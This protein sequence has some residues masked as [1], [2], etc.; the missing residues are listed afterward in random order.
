M[1]S[2]IQ[3]LLSSLLDSPIVESLAAKAGKKAIS[4][5]KAHF[6]L[7]AQQISTAYQDSY[8]YALVAISVGVAAPEQSLAQKIFN[9]KLSREFAEQIDRHYLQPFAKQHGLS[10]E[11]LPAFRK[12]AAKSLKEFAKHKDKLFQIEQVTDDD[13]IALISYRNTSAITDLV[14]EQMRRITPVDDTLADFLRFDGQLG[15]GI[16]FFFRELIRKDDRLEKT[17]AALQREGLCLSVQQLQES[18]EHLKATQQSS[19]FLAD[20]LAPQLKQ[21]QQTQTTW[22]N[23]HEQLIRFSRGFENRLAEMLEWAKDVYSTLEQIHEDVIETQKEVKITKGLVEG[24]LEKLTEMMAR[25]DLS[26]QIKARDEFTIHNSTSLQV[27]RDA[28]S[29]LKQLPPQN[30][31]YSRLSLM[32]G[33]ALSSTGDLEQAERSF[34]KAIESAQKDTEKALAYFNLFQVQLRRKAYTD[35]LKNLR[36]AIAIEPERYALHEIRKYP[37]ERLLGAGG[38]GCVFLCRNDNKLI[39]QKRVVVKCFW[40]NLKGSLEE[41]FKEPFAMR[42]IA[43]DYIPEPL[44]VGYVDF[45]K[46][47]RA[48]FVTEYLD[49]AIDGEMWLE[50]YGPMDLKTGLAVC[51][52]VAK[53]LE[54]AHNAGIFH[55]DLKPA[56]ILLLKKT[57]DVSVKIIDFGL[58]QIATSLRDEMV[59]QQ[60]RSGLSMFGQAIFGTLDYAP[61]EQRGLSQYGSPSAKSDLYA[62]GVTMYRLFS[63]KEAHPF[64]ERYLPNVAELRDILGDCVENDPK[65][66]PSSVRELVSHFSR[67][68]KEEIEVPQ[69]LERVTGSEDDEEADK[70]AWGAAS[71]EDTLEA[72]RA[73]LEGNTLKRYASVANARLEKDEKAWGIACEQDTIEAYQG[74]LEGNTVKKYAVQA[75]ALIQSFAA[76]QDEDAWQKAC[77]QNTLQSYQAYLKGHTLKKFAKEAQTQ[78]QAFAEQQDEDAWQKACQQ[79]TLQSYQ[80]YLN[81]H[82][83]KKYAEEAKKRLRHWLLLRYADNGDGT[84]TDNKTGLIWLKKANCSKR[85]ILTWEEAMQWAAELAHGQYGL[86]DGSKAGDWHLPTRDE[87]KAM[88]DERYKKPALSNAAGTGQWKEGDAFS[89]VQHWYWSSTENSMSSAWFVYLGDGYVGYHGKTRTNYVWAVRGGH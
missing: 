16:L 55:L 45:F 72:Y 63:G 43:G 37:L 34:R 35:A 64:R 52:Q 62:F 7:S 6:T 48:F 23:R 2:L 17:Q 66:R 12:K 13:L 3:T 61:P 68:V 79:N 82:T 88:V 4:T 58:S 67:L 38:M 86:S 70:K 31:E 83:L 51:L 87:W 8:G 54:V 42:D 28:A 29:Q 84:I 53:G 41:V 19:P 30:P 76:Q 32:V 14:L 36:A 5:I 77:Q 33:S 10:S 78:F 57:S 27:I 71:R 65:S 9:S 20:Q 89:G 26:S 1:P 59:V 73:Y 39:R 69:R 85:K 47:E 81:G 75:Q 40:E 18:I 11:D 22:Q 74:Y 46:Q 44:D 21:L 56:N 49:G 15:D 60:S 24:I 80:A 25:Q 50:K